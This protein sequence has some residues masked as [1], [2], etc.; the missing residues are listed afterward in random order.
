MHAC[1]HDVH[2]ASLLGT[3][4]II[5][6]LSQKYPGTVRFIFQPGEELLP[7]GA[8]I[9]I[10]DGV[11]RNPDIQSIY[12]QHVHP[13]LPVGKIGYKAGESM[14]SADEL[15]I[16]VQGK[17]GHAAAPERTVDPILTS[18]QIISELQCIV[19]RNSDPQTPTVLSIGQI[20]SEGGAT[21]ITPA[22]VFMKGTFRTFDESWRRKAHKLIRNIV[23]GIAHA[24]GA[25]AEIEIK[26]GYPVLRNDRQLTMKSAQW[27]KEYMGDDNVVEIPARMSSEDFAFYSHEAPACFYRLGTASVHGDHQS[28]IHTPTFDIDEEAL[29]HS[30]GLMAWLAYQKLSN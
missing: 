10:K 2:T 13:D 30:S 25:E 29:L 21:N 18:A 19:S 7:G 9:M 6:E 15:Y 12:G 14:A 23:T 11:L 8:S 22:K 28:G 20:N 5:N 1:G 26:I 17:G 4:L 3:V 24:H 16:V 27:M